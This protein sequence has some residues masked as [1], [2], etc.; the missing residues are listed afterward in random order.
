MTA[1][2]D[3][4]FVA[5]V[6]EFGAGSASTQLNIVITVDV[7]GLAAGRPIDACAWL[8]DN[9]PRSDGDG[10]AHLRTYCTPGQVLNFIIY[11]VDGNRRADGSFPDFPQIEAI[12]FYQA[13]RDVQAYKT[14]GDLRI[15]G[16]PDRMRSP[17]TPVYRYWAGT[18]E[19]DVEPGTYPYRLLL[20]LPGGAGG[21]RRYIE[22]DTASL[23]VDEPDAA[24]A[25]E[26]FGR[27]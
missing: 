19:S 14:M 10:T 17:Y 15:Y 11:P 20:S 23:E 8:F 4:R 2:S 18:V 9:D 7:A 26:P 6:Q 27:I 21:G 16:A 5:R 3:G 22:L 1:P 25:G 12:I 24:D 13:D